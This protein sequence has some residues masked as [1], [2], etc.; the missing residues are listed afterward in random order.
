MSVMPDIGTL[1]PGRIVSLN[2][3]DRS[4]L[5]T[6][7]A[8]DM[9]GATV[10]EW[11]CGPFSDTWVSVDSDTRWLADPNTGEAYTR[12]EPEPVL[13]GSPPELE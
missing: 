1:E 11:P 2:T 9:N 8:A 7:L 13:A 10:R 12:P 5:V 6:V 4:R 3:E